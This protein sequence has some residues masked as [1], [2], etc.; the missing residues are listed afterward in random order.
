MEEAK[1]IAMV[2]NLLIAREDCQKH[3]RASTT[4]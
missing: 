4:P 1:F 2:T 3:Y